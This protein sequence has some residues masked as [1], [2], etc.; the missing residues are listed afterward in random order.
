MKSISL[1]DPAPVEIADLSAQFF[2]RA[3]DVGKRRD[4]VTAPRLA[5][6][7][8]YTPV[9]LAPRSVLSDLSQLDKYKAVVLADHP[10][11]EQLRINAYTHEK[12]IAF[13]SVCTHGLFGSIFC[14]FGSDFAVVDPTGETPV[15]GILAGIDE[16]GLVTALDESRHGLEDGDYVTF[17]E[18]QGMDT[19]NGAEFQV[20]VKGM[21]RLPVIYG[22]LRLT[23]IPRSLYLLYRR[24]LEPRTVH[25][26]RSVHSG[27]EAQNYQ[28]QVSCGAA[29]PAGFHHLRL[30]QV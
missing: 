21:L 6:L 4:E 2:L 7:N 26:W 27:Q 24:C 30:R 19:V 22:G 9:Q 18:V 29:G 28:F 17:S 20:E 11:S 16:T 8:N 12:K 3:D 13:V 10:M 23:R 15:S 1:Y 14:D 25:Q 5:E